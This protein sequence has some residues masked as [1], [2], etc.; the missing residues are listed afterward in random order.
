MGVSAGPA[1]SSAR[2]GRGSASGCSGRRSRARCRPWLAGPQP[3]GTG[4]AGRRPPD[5][6]TSPGWYHARE[7][8]DVEAV[9]RAPEAA[10][11]AAAVAAHREAVGH[12]RAVL[13]HDE[14][15]PAAARAELLEDYSVEAYLSGLSGEAVSA[16]KAAVDLR[17]AAGDR[18]Q[19]GEALR[20]L[21]R[22]HWW[23]GNRREA[24][25]A[26]ARAIAVLEPLPPATSWPWPTAT[27][28]S[29]TCWPT[30]A[31]RRW[32][33]PRGRSSWPGGWTTR[34]R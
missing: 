4:G 5:G 14:R 10:R 32:A 20:W 27:R 15:I 24:E 11:Q 13:A 8:G 25:A 33:G 6:S 23:D 19:L 17:E 18:E 31:R 30:A 3:A 26:A 2:G 21:S 28:P 16:R 29:W 1:Q 9:L 22:L 7:A 12:Y 34:R